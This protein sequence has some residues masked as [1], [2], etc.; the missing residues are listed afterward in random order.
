MSR[1]RLRCTALS[2]SGWDEL[3]T[4]RRSG[5]RAS[6][7]AGVSVATLRSSEGEEYLLLPLSDGAFVKFSVANG[8]PI[9]PGTPNAVEV[10]CF[11]SPKRNNYGRVYTRGDDVQMIVREGCPVHLK[12]C[13]PVDPEHA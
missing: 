4:S 6:Q 2:E 9:L 3:S 8:V 5:L 12:R 1:R 7:T 10:G 11:R 13:G